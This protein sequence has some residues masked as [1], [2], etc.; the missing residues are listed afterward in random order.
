[1]RMLAS[2]KLRVAYC[3]TSLVL[4]GASPT[5]AMAQV[6]GGRLGLVSSEETGFTAGA[7]LSFA[8]SDRLSVQPELV[9]AEKTSGAAF[10]RVTQEAGRTVIS[11][12]RAVPSIGYLDF[13][14]VAKLHMSVFGL[15]MHLEAGPSASFRVVC[16]GSVTIRRFDFNTGEQL[17]D[18]DVAA[19]CDR[20]KRT[21][22]ALVTGIGVDIS[23]FSIPITLDVRDHYGLVV[24][25]DT[26]DQGIKNRF[27]TF[28]VSV[29]IRSPR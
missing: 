13:L 6:A 26:I 27:A 15:P 14:G 3:L 4:W 10:I 19:D 12:Q 7:Y 29:Q 8:L 2:K 18:Q 17:P 25:V 20:V 1:M 5:V 22:L 23:I 28:T 24:S 9:Y 21:D 11:E 16:G